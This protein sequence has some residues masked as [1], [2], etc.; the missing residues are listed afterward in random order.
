ML[1]WRSGGLR[2]DGIEAALAEVGLALVAD[3]NGGAFAVAGDTYP[4]RDLLKRHG[5]RWSG[6]RQRWLFRF[7]ATGLAEASA[8]FAGQ[9]A[10]RPH[11]HGH[12][13]RLRTK[14]REA[15]PGALADYE[16]LEL[17]L[18]FSV[19][20]RDTKPIAKA[21]LER[22]GGLGAVLA[23]EPARLAE[24]MGALPEDA[25]SGLRESRDDDARFTQALLKAVHELLQRVLREEVRQREAIDSPEAL[26]SYLQLAMAHATAEHLRLLFLDRKDRLIRDEIHGRGTVDEA[27]LYP[28]EVLKRALELGASAL[29]LVHN[30]PSGDPTPSR[31]DIDSTRQ[32]AAMLEQ[33]GV[34]LHDHLIVGSERIESLRELGVLA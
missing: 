6:S 32:M 13:E 21:M 1:A 31:A 24:C 17:L 8:P 27:P 11:Y 26:R 22:L 15:G 12:R 34:K 25:G 5:A 9:T 4:H 20:R 30:H 14:L 19:H 29:I 18:F 10:P 28:R 7:D 16:L 2:R 33:V 23:A 3:G